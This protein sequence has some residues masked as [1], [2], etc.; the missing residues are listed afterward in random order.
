MTNKNASFSNFTRDLLNAQ[1]RNV[2][3]G[4]AFTRTTLKT[5]LTEFCNV[6]ARKEQVESVTIHLKVYDPSLLQDGE[7]QYLKARVG[8]T[9]HDRYPDCLSDDDGNRRLGSEQRRPHYRDDPLHST[10]AFPF[11]A[12]PRG[13]LQLVACNST[14]PWQTLLPGRYSSTGTTAESAA[15]IEELAIVRLNAGISAEIVQDNWARKQGRSKI[16]ATAQ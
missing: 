8:R 6:L 14:S 4:R 2:L 5:I 16:L 1:K 7:S 13:G 9:A 11:S 15:A 12:L 10:M 3:A